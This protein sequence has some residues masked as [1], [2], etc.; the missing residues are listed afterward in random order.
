[1]KVTLISHTKLSNEYLNNLN[2]DEFVKYNKGE[3][4]DGQALAF[5]AIRTCYSAGKPSELLN[6]EGAKYF[7]EDR[8]INR[9]I[10][11]IVK[12]GHTSTLEGITF[13]FA[14]EGVSRALL[15]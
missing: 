7:G 15:A 13:N 2:Y 1:M 4:T 10:N 3:I 14:I 5:T 12:S 6:N 8:D 11:H 9:L